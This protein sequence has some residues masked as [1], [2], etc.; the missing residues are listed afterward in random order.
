MP[1]GA[2]SVVINDWAGHV[3]GQHALDLPH[4]LLALFDVGLLRL[5]VEQ[6]VDLG[7]Q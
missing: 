3:L 2:G 7:V 1:A 6:L 5:L 4:D